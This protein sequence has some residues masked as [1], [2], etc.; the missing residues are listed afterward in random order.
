MSNRTLA[1]SVQALAQSTDFKKDVLKRLGNLDKV[2]VL[3]SR[4]LVATYVEPEMTAG[5]IIKPQKNIEEARYQGKTGLV[6][7]KGP[8]AFKYADSYSGFLYEGP[9]IKVGDWVIY[10]PSDGREIGLRGVA[11]RTVDSSLIMMRVADPETVF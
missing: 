2:D 8:T 6:L 7:K 3:G 4:V 5:G 9:E 11:C 10:Y 1:L